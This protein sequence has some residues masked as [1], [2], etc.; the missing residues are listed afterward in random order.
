MTY[1]QTPAFSTAET[2]LTLDDVDALQKQP[3]SQL[4]E[5]IGSHTVAVTTLKPT[6]ITRWYPVQRALDYVREHININIYTQPAVIKTEISGKAKGADVLG[7]HLSWADID[8]PDGEDAPTDLD[9]WRVETAETLLPLRPSYILDSGRGLWLFWYYEQRLTPEE[10][11]AANK[12]HINH[13]AALG[14]IADSVANA[15]RLCRFPSSRNQKTNRRATL[16]AVN[17][18]LCPPAPANTKSATTAVATEPERQKRRRS[19]KPKPAWHT[20]KK[21]SRAVANLKPDVEWERFRDVIFAMHGG[22]LEWYAKSPAEQRLIKKMCERHFQ[23]GDKW[24]D[25]SQSE[26]DHIWRTSHG[27]ADRPH[28]TFEHIYQWAASG[29]HGDTATMQREPY[30]NTGAGIYQALCDLNLEFRRNVRTN[31]VEVRVKPG[32]SSPATLRG[33]S[34]TP[35][36]WTRLEGHKEHLYMRVLPDNAEMLTGDDARPFEVSRQ[37][38]EDAIS[39]S[40]ETVDPYIIYI[41]NLPDW[42]QTPRL[43]DFP[44]A[45]LGAEDTALARWTWKSMLV[46]SIARAYDTMQVN[47]HLDEPGGDYEYVPAYIDDGYGETGKTTAIQ[48][49]FPRTYRFTSQIEDLSL[50]L[51]TLLYRVGSAAIVEIG[52]MGNIRKANIEKLKAF[53]SAR[54][55]TYDAKYRDSNDYDRRFVLVATANRDEVGNLPDDINLRRFVSIRVNPPARGNGQTNA[56]YVRTYLLK[57]REQLL[58]EALHLYRD[59]WNYRLPP[60]LR[61]AREAA[62]KRYRHQDDILETIAVECEQQIR[63]MLEKHA[64]GGIQISGKLLTGSDGGTFNDT[65]SVTV[66]PFEDGLSRI[67]IEGIGNLDGELLNNWQRAGLGRALLHRGWRKSTRRE[68]REPIIEA[69]RDNGYNRS[70]APLEWVYYAPARLR[71]DLDL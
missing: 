21:L 56:D 46:A 60:Q 11:V 43:T 27:D 12:E 1:S 35:D 50:D 4:L 18:N 23:R 63:V 67:D 65:V 57:Y 36:G 48:H 5:K 20:I 71:Q 53:L 64:N 9:L 47:Q 22:A 55:D 40:V 24:D 33:D 45:V 61:A 42:D 32:Q 54:T 7:S 49:L 2:I 14:V 52:E 13:C 28:Y 44:V 39:G 16:Y 69:A 37:R 10:T 41:E 6:V 58:A 26:I 25:N 68:R 59:G 62:N 15:D 3:P 17:H 31:A 70:S 51:R 34:M 66:C 38:F 8:P 30:E 29:I 19:A